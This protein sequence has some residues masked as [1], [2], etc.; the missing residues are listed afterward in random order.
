MKSYRLA[1]VLLLAAS[2]AAAAPAAI[3]GRPRLL[4]GLADEA[5]QFVHG[6]SV[7]HAA[8]PGAQLEVAFSPHGGCVQLVEKLI[9][10]SRREIRML[11]YGLTNPQVVAALVAAR[12]RGIDVR[13]VADYKANI[14]ED[15]SGKA[16]AALNILVN[17]GIPVRVVSAY[18]IHHDK[19]VFTENSVETGSFNFTAAAEKS[20]SENAL[21][22]WNDPQLV[23]TY[24]QHWERN[25]S[26]GRD[27]QSSY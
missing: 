26:Q 25:W 6:S 20:N 15:K 13:V 12:K 10:S 27:Y 7:P 1:H 9:A 2:L 4:A 3:A 23:A 19:V 14:S 5:S 8:A 18:P 24:R 16:R 22:V 21:V 11:A 17:A